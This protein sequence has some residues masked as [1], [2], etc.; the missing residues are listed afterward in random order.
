MKFRTKVVE[1][2]A[3]RLDWENWNDICA[4]VSPE[5]F[6]NGCYLNAE[7]FPTEDVT[8]RMG[9]F[10]NTLEGQMLA[11]HG[12]WIVKGLAGE[13][14]AVKDEIFQKSYESVETVEAPKAVSRC[15]DC[16]CGK[17][18]GCS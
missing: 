8:D 17:S 18:E 9:L 6:G 7:G 13:F 10:I 3:I 4:F 14:Y 1:K 11:R 12:D 15:D 5:A 2:E 16:S